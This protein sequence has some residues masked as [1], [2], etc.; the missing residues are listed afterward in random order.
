MLAQRI[1]DYV[2]RMVDPPIAPEE[3]LW[4]SKGV[5]LLV[6]LLTGLFIW[7][8]I[9]VAGTVVAAGVCAA[10]YGPTQVC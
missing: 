3:R 5:I 4:L 7:L 8:V 2:L 10:W 1:E 6:G 9:L